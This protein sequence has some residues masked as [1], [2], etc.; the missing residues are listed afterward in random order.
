MSASSVSAAAYAGNGYWGIP[1]GGTSPNTLYTRLF[2]PYVDVQNM[3]G[4]YGSILTTVY[5]G[6]PYTAVFDNS[7]SR[8]D[9]RDV[10]RTVQDIHDFFQTFAPGFSFTNQLVP[11]QVNINLSCN[12]YYW[13]GA[14]HFYRREA[15][16]NTNR[17]MGGGTVQA[18]CQ[19]IL[20]GDGSEGWVKQRRRHRVLMTISSV[21]AAAST[22]RGGI[23]MPITPQVS[24]RR[25][26]ARDP[27]RGA[28]DHR[29]IGTRCRTRSP[30][31][32]A[33]VILPAWTALGRVCSSR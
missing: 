23:A 13:G 12:A 33:G 27:L 16:A 20:G 22:A 26:R 4:T 5:P 3:Q 15:A 17:M 32:A 10:F 18:R 31:T 19:A 21:I 8:A 29:P 30:T 7:N 9:E 11:A 2:S 25:G 6:V 1:F 28:G 24:R 14:I